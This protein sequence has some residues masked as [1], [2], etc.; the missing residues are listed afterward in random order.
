MPDRACIDSGR[1]LQ[2]ALKA[3]LSSQL[4][5]RVRPTGSPS[6]LQQKRGLSCRWRRRMGRSTP[7]RDHH[8]PRFWAWKERPGACER[9]A[10]DATSTSCP[11]LPPRYPYPF[12]P[13]DLDRHLARPACVWLWMIHCRSRLHSSKQP[14]PSLARALIKWDAGRYMHGID[15]QIAAW[16]AVSAHVTSIRGPNSL[17]VPTYA[18]PFPCAFR[19]GK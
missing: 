8:D 7:R 18:R 11:P 1:H 15:H 13:I 4:S 10:L 16:V 5:S 12:S 3:R 19:M 17:H 6:L 14:N 2:N 9:P